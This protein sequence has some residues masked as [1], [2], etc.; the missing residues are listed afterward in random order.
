MRKYLL[1]CLFSVS[2][3]MST[4]T[5]ATIDCA[6]GNDPVLL[7][8]GTQTGEFCCVSV[9]NGG[10][11]SCANGSCWVC[12]E[13]TGTCAGPSSQTVGVCFE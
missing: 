10:A 9:G 4:L 7:T 2:I 8:N 6:D 3:S 5:G 11:L 13:T 1:Y 12:V